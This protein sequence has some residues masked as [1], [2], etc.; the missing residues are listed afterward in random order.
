MRPCSSASADGK[1]VGRG[2]GQRRRPARAGVRANE[3]VARRR[4]ARR[5]PRRRQGRRRPGRR[6]RR[7]SRIDEA[8]AAAGAAV[9]R[10]CRGLRSLRPG[11]RLGIDPG[12]ARIGVARSDPTGFL[13]TP[14][15]TVRRGRGD[16]AR[17]ARL[18]ARG[19]RRSRSSSGCRARS[20]A[21]RGRRP[22]KVREFAAALA[23]RVAP[24]PVRLQDERL[25]TVSRGGYAA[26]PGEEGGQTA[27]RGRPG[28]G[29]AD[30]AAR[31]GHRAGDRSSTRRDRHRETS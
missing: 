20:P 26:R 3:L 2:G 5:R 11:V 24:V 30:P 6:H 1:V 7:V 22:S 29:G 12:D 25:T 31:P 10:A 23:A 4:P 14:V 28:C 21:A 19:R 16:L 18:R 9:A 13:A 27:G 8:L 15:E 17:I